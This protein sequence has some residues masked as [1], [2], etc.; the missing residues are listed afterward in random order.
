M[1]GKVKDKGG[2]VKD[3][4]CKV[5]DKYGTVYNKDSWKRSW[6]LLATALR[7]RT[8]QACGRI[9]RPCPIVRPPHIGAPV[10]GKYVMEDG[11]CT[12]GIVH[13]LCNGFKDSIYHYWQ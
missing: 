5:S 4:G 6:L 13:D 2:K 1:G 3:K 11:N 9:S 12:F 10:Q 8:V 7:P